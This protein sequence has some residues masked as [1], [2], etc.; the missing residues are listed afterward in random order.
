M[1]IA[2]TRFKTADGTEFANESDAIEHEA[3]SLRCERALESTIGKRRK[4]DCKHYVQHDI[5]IALQAKRLMLEIICEKH[6][7]A[8]PVLKTDADQVHPRSFV[9]R[10]ADDI[11]GP[12]GKAWGRLCCIDFDNGREYEQPFFALNPDKAPTVEMN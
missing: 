1:A 10:L 2:V 9:G 12:I 3:L 11:G 4:I 8:Y 5:K 7:D 6:G